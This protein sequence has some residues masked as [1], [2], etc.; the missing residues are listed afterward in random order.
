M[1]H[2]GVRYRGIL[3]HKHVRVKYEVRENLFRHIFFRVCISLV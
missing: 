1:S 3:I 2:Y